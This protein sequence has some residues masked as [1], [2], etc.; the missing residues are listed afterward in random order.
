[1]FLICVKSHSVSLEWHSHKH[2]EKMS[3]GWLSVLE[4]ML[5]LTFAVRCRC[6]IAHTNGFCTGT[7]TIL[8]LIPPDPLTLSLEHFSGHPW[9]TDYLQL[10]TN[11]KLYNNV[12]ACLRC[13]YSHSHKEQTLHAVHRGCLCTHSQSESN[14][15]HSTSWMWTHPWSQRANFAHCTSWLLAHSWSLR[16]NLVCLALWVWVYPCFLFL[17]RRLS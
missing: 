2:V 1:M 12:S 16:A 4:E 17:K 11:K 10:W 14:H 8:M 15:M 13:E 9:I 3:S 5:A 6:E 7:L